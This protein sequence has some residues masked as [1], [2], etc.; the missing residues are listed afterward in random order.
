MIYIHPSIFF[1]KD[2]CDKKYHQN[3]H[4]GMLSRVLQS[5]NPVAAKIMFSFIFGN[6]LHNIFEGVINVHQ[7][8]NTISTSYTL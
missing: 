7:N 8:L 6:I 1:L 5:Y 2:A 3:S 4:S